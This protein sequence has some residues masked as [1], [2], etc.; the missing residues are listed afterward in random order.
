MKKDYL[1]QVKMF[2]YLIIDHSILN[3]LSYVEKMK[4]DYLH[5]VK[6]FIYLIIDHSILNLLSYVEKMKRD[7]L[8]QMKILIYLTII[9]HGRKKQANHFPYESAG[10]LQ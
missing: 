9:Y 3:L 10:T 6:M 1:H 5:Q 2:I 4:R 7:Y 8:H